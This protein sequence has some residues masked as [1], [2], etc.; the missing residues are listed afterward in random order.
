MKQEYKNL[1]ACL[2][3]MGLGG[4]V[5][6]KLEEKKCPDCKC[7]GRE[8]DDE[9]LEEISKAADHI[10]H[11]SDYVL[12]GSNPKNPG[13]YCHPIV[14]DVKDTECSK[15]KYDKSENAFSC[16]WCDKTVDEVQC[17]CEIRKK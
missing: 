16:E 12:K 9:W 7:Y 11:L 6:E 3:V 2:I 15:C 5:G 10:A 8:I 1:I 4:C 17:K 14:L 13:Y